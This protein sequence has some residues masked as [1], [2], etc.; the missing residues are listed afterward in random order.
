[1]VKKCELCMELRTK[2]IELRAC[3]HIL[4]YEVSSR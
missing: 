4:L 3:S 1:M 2:K